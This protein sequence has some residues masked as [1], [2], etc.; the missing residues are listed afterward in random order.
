MSSPK[1]EHPA[2]GR[3][4]DEFWHDVA[5]ARALRRHTAACALKATPTARTPVARP[6]RTSTHALLQ[7]LYSSV[8]PY[9]FSARAENTFVPSSYVQT[10]FRTRQRASCRPTSAAILGFACTRVWWVHVG[11]HFKVCA[12]ACVVSPR[13]AAILRFVCTRVWLVLVGR[14]IINVCVYARARARVKV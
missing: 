10:L 3:R 11:R 8:P 4:V 7:C 14:H 1:E 12:H 2:H 13:L 9:I 5:N 6:E